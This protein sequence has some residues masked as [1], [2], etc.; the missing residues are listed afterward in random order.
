MNKLIK[1]MIIPILIA[2]LLLFG[3][4]SFASLHSKWSSGDLIFYDGTQDIFTIKDGTDGILFGEDD[5]GVDVKFFGAST[6]AYILWDESG[7]ELVLEK[8]DIHLGDT[9]FILFGDATAGDVSI[10]WTG[11]ILQIS[12]ATDDTGTINIGNGT[13]DIDFKIFLGTSTEYVLFDVGNSCV[14]FGESDQGIDISIFGDTAAKKIFW[15]TSKNELSITHSLPIATTGGLDAGFKTTWA[16]EIAITSG[17][18]CAMSINCEPKAATDAY[19]V[20][21]AEI[22]TY[23]ASDVVVS[24]GPIHG[25]FV[26]TQGGGTIASDFYSLYVYAAPSAVPSGSSAVVRLENN[27]TTDNRLNTFIEFVGGKGNYAMTF[28]PL[29]TQTAWAYTGTPGTPSGWLKIKVGSDDRWV[30]LYSV[31]P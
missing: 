21:G 28:G 27:A 29:A 6:T 23:L 3:M 5:L 9:D 15:D 10:N 11:S 16:N 13:A 19:K 18:L 26:E 1:I 4:S 31:A 7:D 25:L 30:Q 12:P 22:C 14:N 24:N 2:L 8:A 17:R 20:I